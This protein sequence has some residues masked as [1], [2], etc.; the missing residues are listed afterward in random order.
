MYGSKYY[1]HHALVVLVAPSM[2]HQEVIQYSILD[3]LHLLFLLH[4]TRRP[5]E[6][7]SAMVVD[8]AIVSLSKV[9]GD[10]TAHKGNGDGAFLRS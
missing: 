10:I 7:L 3:H 1:F 9:R 2:D 4:H 5:M 6:K 8:L